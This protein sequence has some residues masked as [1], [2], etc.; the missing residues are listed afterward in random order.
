MGKILKNYRLEADNRSALVKRASARALGYTVVELVVT[1]AI[2][3]IATAI[4]IP[5][6]RNAGKTLSIRSAVVSVS[7]AIQSARYQAISHG[8]QYQL[9]LNKAASTYQFQSNPCLPPTAPC[10]AN[11]GGT[12]P[13]SGSSVAATINADTTLLFH[14]SGLVQAT[15]GAQTFI[16]TYAGS[17]ETFT[18][19]NYGKITVT[20]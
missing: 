8:Y 12:V 5:L 11:V 7:G 15:T 10:W 4:A 17:P 6:V 1:V 18:V 19:T 3:I 16:L 13:L 20:P 2:V 14:P 9:V